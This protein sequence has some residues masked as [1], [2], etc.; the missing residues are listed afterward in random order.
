M[1]VRYSIWVI[2]VF[3]AGW[4]DLFKRHI[5]SRLLHLVS[6]FQDIFGSPVSRS[7]VRDDRGLYQVPS[8]VV[9]DS[10]QATDAR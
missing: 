7:I 10:L 9:A 2:Y 4:R 3:A 1:G 8:V 6:L 5:G